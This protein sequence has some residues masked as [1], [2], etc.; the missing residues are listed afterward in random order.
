MLPIIIYIYFGLKEHSKSSYFHSYSYFIVK[1]K[2]YIL[3]LNKYSTY[4]V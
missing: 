4:K 2:K 1:G 3:R